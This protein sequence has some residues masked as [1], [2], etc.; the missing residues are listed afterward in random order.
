MR[1][2]NHVKRVQLNSFKIFSLVI[3]FIADGI[4]LGQTSGQLR[5]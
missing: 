5:R 1:I 3:I 2:C 4:G